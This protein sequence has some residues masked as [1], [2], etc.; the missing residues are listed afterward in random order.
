MVAKASKKACARLF[1]TA[2]KRR[3][4]NSYSGRC[5]TQRR[6]YCAAIGAD[7]PSNGCP[8]ATESLESLEYTVADNCRFK[9][10]L[11]LRNLA[12]SLAACRLSSEVAVDVL[13]RASAHEADSVYMTNDVSRNDE[14]TQKA[15]RVAPPRRP[16]CTFSTWLKFPKHPFNIMACRLQLPPTLNTLTRALSTHGCHAP[17][18]PTTSSRVYIFFIRCL[19]HPGYCS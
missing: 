19:A 12:L 3:Q 9:L 10:G 13:L 6:Y 7:Q 15:P 5:N 14:R 8:R 16:L 18:C 2:A 17:R 4:S 1:A 11:I